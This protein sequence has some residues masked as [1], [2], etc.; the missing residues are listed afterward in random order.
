[1]CAA[2]EAKAAGQNELSVACTKLAQ[3]LLEDWLA[4]A[5]AKGPVS[6]KSKRG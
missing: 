6:A 1:L 3:N 5:K 4:D 2:G